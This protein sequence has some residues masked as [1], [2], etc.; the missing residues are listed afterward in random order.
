[1]LNELYH[2]SFDAAISIV[3]KKNKESHVYVRIL[4][5]KVIPVLGHSDCVNSYLCYKLEYLSNL[6]KRVNG[7]CVERNCKYLGDKYFF[8]F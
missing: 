5:F 2:I 7:T 4:V 6:N 1:M 8:P 3:L